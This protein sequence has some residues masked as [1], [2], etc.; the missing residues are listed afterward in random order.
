M[1]DTRMERI[2]LYVPPEEYAEVKASGACWDDTSKLWYIGGDREPAPFS[3]WSGEAGEA[4]FAL[5]SDEALVA[6]AQT[7]CVNCHERMEVICIYCERGIDA[8][9]GEP[10]TRFTV[11]NIWAMD[12]ALAAQLERWRSFRKETGV[13]SED[14]CFANHCP[15]CGAMQE[16]FLLHAEPGDVF[17]CI[18]LAEPGSIEFTPLSG[19]IQLSG[20]CGFGV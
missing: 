10:M 1:L 15:H 18:P 16:D 19:R 8:E 17:F 5:T 7:A 2:Y 9:T 13:G 3:R 6:S 14:G 4:E 12:D 11:S 20:D